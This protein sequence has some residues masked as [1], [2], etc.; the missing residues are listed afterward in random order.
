MIPDF[1]L[2]H[3]LGSQ[4]R[5][6]E[7]F[8][9]DLKSISLTPVAKKGLG[10]HFTFDFLAPSFEPHKKGDFDRKSASFYGEVNFDYK[11]FGDD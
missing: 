9:T 8:Y 6:G 1:E 4:R 3:M 5:L 11:Q 7:R 2:I 10:K